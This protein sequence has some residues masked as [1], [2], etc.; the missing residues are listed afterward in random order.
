M[1]AASPVSPSRRRS[2]AWRVAVGAFLLVTL[3]VVVQAAAVL[4]VVSRGQQG[5]DGLSAT[6][7]AVGERLGPALQAD[8]NLDVAGFLR[9]AAP[10]DRLFVI[11]RGGATFGS[12]PSREL[13]TQVVAELNRSE[14]RDVP[15]TW[16]QSIFR[17]AAVMIDARL[18]GI[19]GGVPPTPLERYGP[20]V[21]AVVIGVVVA[22][23][24]L[25]TAF[26][27][28]PLRRRLRSVTVAAQRLG[29]GDFSARA[30]RDG[31]DEVTDLATAFNFMADELV[32]RTTRL[33]ASDEAR[34]Q[35]VADVSHELMTPVTTIRG[36]LETLA[37]PDVQLDAAGRRR[38]VVT[39]RRETLRLERLIG[40]LL[41]SAR[42]EAGGVE[43]SKAEMD[44]RDLF[45]RVVD[46]HEPECLDRDIV[47]TVVVAPEARV[48]VGDAFRL[49][50]ALTN[51]VSN[52]LRH[53]R[54]RGTIHLAAE[55][56]TAW[57][58][59]SVSD[60]GEGIASNELPLIFDRFYKADG[61]RRASSN[62]CGL[63]LSI[64]RAIVTRH[65]GQVRAAS[66]LGAGTTISIELP[67]HQDSGPA[68]GSDSGVRAR[69][70][71]V[72]AGREAQGA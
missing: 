51:L 62:G 40:D 55:R 17:A 26:I 58:V 12:L 46:R 29:T 71:S 36:Y 63:G 3:V 23:T 45:Q 19:V 8:P 28:R 48:V 34:R 68:V 49:E 42:L 54:D 2:L 15:V 1:V 33:E 56:S 16:E 10:S 25:A 67:A 24:L 65:G 9:A 22:G 35:L 27:V 47:M 32:A 14:L 30:N 7:R 38:Y 13:T 4:W 57:V 60:T 50:Q 31:A 52:A 20:T 43:L 70:V 37:M 72:P 44:V 6:T 21:L 11:M 64:V 18:A 41:D 61:R 69:P 53:S 59:L 5:P 66:E 39:A